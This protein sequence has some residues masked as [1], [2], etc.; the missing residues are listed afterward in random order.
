MSSSAKALNDFSSALAGIASASAKNTAQSQ[1]F[2]REQMAFQQSSNEQ[3]MAFSS[4][5]AQK[6]RD[7]QAMMSNTTHQREVKDLIAAGL[8]PV[9]SANA[10]ASTP[11][12]ATGSG[13][14]SSG[15]SGQVDS[16]YIN[17]MASIFAQQLAMKNNIDIARI[18]Q[19]TQLKTAEMGYDAA[20]S[21]ANI[22]AKSQQAINNSQLQFQ[23]LHPQNKF[24]AISSA[25][26]LIGNYLNG[27]NSSAKRT[28][29]FVDVLKYSKSILA[30]IEQAGIDFHNKRYGK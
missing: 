27:G 14:S 23:E 3:A 22:S 12:G 25:I 6:N 15:A 11:S 26:N 29:N 21:T 20:V 1:D 17:A 13:F 24:G 16:S 30:K 8:N 4:A 18:N 2:A 5:E 7:W 19:E 9:L 28:S 10:G